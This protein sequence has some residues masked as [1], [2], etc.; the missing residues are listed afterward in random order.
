MALKDSPLKKRTVLLENTAFNAS[1]R[2]AATSAPHERL[3]PGQPKSHKKTPKIAYKL[4]FTLIFIL[5][6]LHLQR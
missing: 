3:I 4:I 2:S 6:K 1:F 5:P